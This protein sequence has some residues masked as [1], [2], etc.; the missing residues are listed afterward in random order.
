[1]NQR[2]SVVYV[3]NGT[4]KSDTFGQYEQSSIHMTGVYSDSGTVLTMTKLDEK[5]EV[6]YRHAEVIERVTPLERSEESKK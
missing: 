2:I 1:M 5:R 4:T 3:V 6:F